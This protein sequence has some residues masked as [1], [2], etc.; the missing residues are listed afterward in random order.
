M[1]EFSPIHKKDL[2]LIMKWR[3]S[4]DI[5]RFMITDFKIDKKTQIAW[6]NKIKKDSNS[7]Y[8]LIKYKNIPVGLNS[9]N[10][11]DWSNH[12]CFG[13]FYIGDSKYRALL[14]G[15]IPYL[16]LNFLF[17]NT[18]IIKSIANIFADN[19]NVIKLYKNV[20]YKEVGKFKNHILKNGKRYDMVYLEFLK[21]DWE[22]NQ[23]LFSN[24]KAIF[25][26]GT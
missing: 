23:K 1:I 8:W 4:S 11:I 18:K 6:Y 21:S 24:Y 25:K 15:Y 9:L 2:D 20:G 17:S 3:T 26:E 5:T 22:K 14:G 16:T 19:N 10:D 13:G 7:I 12:Y